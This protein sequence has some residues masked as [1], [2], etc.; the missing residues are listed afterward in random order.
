MQREIRSCLEGREVPFLN[1]GFLA[2][3]SSYTLAFLFN[4]A[5]ESDSLPLLENWGFLSGGAFTFGG[6]PKL[7]NL[8]LLQIP[9]DFLT[10]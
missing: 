10:C 3:V 5:V 1:M 4:G 8:P 9:A 2:S 6:V 7:S